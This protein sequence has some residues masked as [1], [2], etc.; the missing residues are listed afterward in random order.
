MGQVNSKPPVIIVHGMWSTGASLNEIRQAFE[1][2]GYEVYCPDLPGHKPKSQMDA[3][4]KSELIGCDIETYV[5]AICE[6]VDSMAEAPILVG[7]SMGGLV[8]QLVAVRKNLAALVMISSAPP[9]G[10]HGWSWSVLRTFGRNVFIFPLWKRLTE[11]RIQNIRYGIANTQSPEVQQD[12]YEKTT[13]ESGLATFQLSMW[14]LFRLAPT[15][16]VY[17]RITCPVLMLGGDEDKITP[18]GIQRKV[19]RLFAGKAK[20]LELPG[21]CHWTVG[22]TALPVVYRHID[23]WLSE[24]R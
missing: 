22:G 1:Q 3:Q 6:V 8:A 19:H 13:Y 9:A 10:V 11:L 5:S 2:D 16:V 23:S 18:I 4:A 24:I 21:V 12:L 17:E 15:R 7:H 14:F 20:L